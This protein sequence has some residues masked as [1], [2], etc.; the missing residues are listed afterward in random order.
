[1]GDVINENFS[2]LRTDEETLID[3]VFEER[4][5]GLLVGDS[6]HQ[7]QTSPVT[8]TQDL[9]LRNR[10]DDVSQGVVAQSADSAVMNLLAN[11]VLV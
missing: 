1:M 11:D 5:E 8:Q 9:V 3:D 7:G 10:K 6:Q 2:D 4:H